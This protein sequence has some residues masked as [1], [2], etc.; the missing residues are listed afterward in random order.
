MSVFGAESEPPRRGG[1]SVRIGAGA[2]ALSIV[3]VILAGIGLF[4]GGMEVGRRQGIQEG[5]AQ[6]SPTST[7]AEDVL[8][9]MLPGP[10]S[11]LATADVESAPEASPGEAL[12]VEVDPAPAETPPT[13]DSPRAAELEVPVARP[14]AWEQ[15]S[16]A[17]P[18]PTG[19]G[20]AW[21]VQVLATPDEREAL[22]LVQ[23][24]EGAGYPVFVTPTRKEGLTWHRVRVGT[25]G[26]ETEAQTA[27]RELRRKFQLPTW[28]LE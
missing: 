13:G 23:K 6:M 25:Y 3:L 16:G 26:A 14:K 22:L 5:I 8:G 7:P 9:P 18:A 15:L 20:R 17:R 2:L 21:A 10:P 28:V 24:L 1:G 4:L 12:P 11:E 19:A 27:A